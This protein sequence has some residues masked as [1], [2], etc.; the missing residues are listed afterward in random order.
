MLPPRLASPRHA[1]SARGNRDPRLHI[2]VVTAN[3]GKAKAVADGLLIGP[4]P[5]LGGAK[6]DD[7][8]RVDLHHRKAAAIELSEVERRAHP[9]AT[10][11]SPECFVQKPL[12]SAIPSAS[13]ASSLACL[14]SDSAASRR[15]STAPAGRVSL[16]LPPFSRACARGD[17][18]LPRTS[19]R[20]AR[21][22]PMVSTSFS[23]LGP[24]GLVARAAQRSRTAWSRVA[25]AI[26]LCVASA[27]QVRR[28]V[29][30]PAKS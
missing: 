3:D 8:G 21:K 29:V 26:G 11:R 16:P 17:S 7:R 13:G 15:R 2:E 22:A 28:V 25:G 12:V 27:H 23:A 20:A 5:V 9:Q 19:A 30:A 10:A 24:A 6:Q 18:Q 4:L 1:R 14:C